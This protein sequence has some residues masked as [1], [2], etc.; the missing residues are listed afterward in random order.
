MSPL[1]EW[2]VG[3][4]LSL[5]IL[6]Q[7]GSVLGLLLMP[8]VH[9]RLHFLSPATSVAPMLVAGAVVTVEALDHQGIFA[10][11]VA[12]FMLVFQPI[13]THATARAARLKEHGD[14]RLQPGETA[15]RP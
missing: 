12:L 13:L 9:D 7:L 8:H 11:L 10:I 1:Q 15:R 2:V 4:L 6:V 14:W 5:A 3:V